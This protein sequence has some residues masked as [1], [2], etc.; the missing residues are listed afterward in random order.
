M[1]AVRGTVCWEECSARG[2]HHPGDGNSPAIVVPAFLFNR[3][4]IYLYYIVGHVTSGEKI[5]LA[6]PASSI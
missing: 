4:L 2:Q 3:H 1:V 5:A 6:G